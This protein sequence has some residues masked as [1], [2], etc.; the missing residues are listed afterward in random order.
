MC[1]AV[2]LCDFRVMALDRAY[3]FGMGCSNV[4]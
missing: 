1:D 3:E 4:C 2:G